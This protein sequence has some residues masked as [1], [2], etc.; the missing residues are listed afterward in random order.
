MSIEQTSDPLVDEVRR[1]RREIAEQA[2]HD[3]NRLAEELRRVEREYAGRKGVFAGVTVESAANVVRSW[4]DMTD[5][6]QDALINDVRAIR[7]RL[8]RERNE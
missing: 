5:A 3:L 8:A 1:I 7:E 2:G 6:P 4:G